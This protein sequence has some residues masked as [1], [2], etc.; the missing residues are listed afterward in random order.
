MSPRNDKLH[1]K[2]A[3]LASTD[4]S[5]I[6]PGDVATY[7]AAWQQDH[8]STVAVVAARWFTHI[9]DLPALGDADAVAVSLTASPLGQEFGDGPHSAALT[10]R[11][12][13]R[14]TNT[15]KYFSELQVERT[16]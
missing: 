9:P 12:S 6:G 10:L 5:V 7:S 16:R 13:S 15:P 14:C 2:D 3:H 1:G 8:I 4:V 11:S